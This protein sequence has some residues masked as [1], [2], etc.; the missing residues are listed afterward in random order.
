MEHSFD[1]KLAEKYG[2]LEAIML[3]HL[4]YWLM[5]N[6]ANEK[7]CIDGKYWTY[8]TVQAFSAFFP[9]M[10]PKQIRRVMEHLKEE[11]LVVTA[12]YNKDVRDR[13]LWYALTDKGMAE[14]GID[15]T[16]GT[17]AI[18]QMGKS[19][20]PNGQIELPKRENVTFAQTGKALPNIIPNIIPD[21]IPNRESGEETTVVANETPTAIDDNPPCE[22][23]KQKKQVKRKYGEYD[24]VLLS[25][26]DLEKLKNDFPVDWQQ[27][28]DRLSEYI[29]SSGKGYKNHLATIRSWARSESKPVRQQK[30]DVAGTIEF[31]AT[32]LG[33][34]V[35][36]DYNG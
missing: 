12:C 9:Y 30:N 28:I 2:V 36:D 20:C 13:T 33:S 18:Y 3:K 5:K 7:N 14:L 6:K 4:G 23:S 24:N 26:S 17:D 10:S 27:R 15:L 35:Y 29:A 8:N 31:L 25:D 11:E 1:V 16:V 19:D 34:G 32:A 21:I 22:K